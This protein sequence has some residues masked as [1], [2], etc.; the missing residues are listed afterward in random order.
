LARPP[1]IEISVT[2]CDSVP[3]GLS[4]GWSHNFPSTVAILDY[5]SRTCQAF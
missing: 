5:F 4:R 3:I 2:G 1:L